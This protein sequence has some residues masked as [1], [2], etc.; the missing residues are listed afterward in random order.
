MGVPKSSSTNRGVARACAGLGRRERRGPKA[1]LVA[2]AVRR[3]GVAEDGAKRPGGGIARRGALA[4]VPALSEGGRDGGH[5]H[6]RAAVG[7]RGAGGGLGGGAAGGGRRAD[8]HR[9][10]PAPVRGLREPRQRDRAGARA[11]LRDLR[12]HFRRPR[13]GADRGGFR[14]QARGRPVEGAEADPAGPGGHA[15]RPRGVQR[16]QRPARLRASRRGAAH[17]PQRRQRSAHRRKLQPLGAA[18]LVLQRPDRA[19]HGA[20]ALRP[21]LPPRLSRR[22][23]LRRRPADDGGVPRPLARR[24]RRRR[25]RILRPAARDARLRPLARAHPRGGARRRVR[26]LRRQPGDPV[27]YPVRR[28]RPQGRDRADR[29]RLSSSRRSTSTPRGRRRTGSSASSTTCRGST[30]TPTVPSRPPTAPATAASPPSTRSRATTPR[31]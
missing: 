31:T 20:V 14:G 30:T 26:L 22:R 9:R 25:R 16:R 4:M 18:H 27:R 24:R 5:D 15:R 6:G 17:R 21:R 7:G 12:Q 13:G 11:R 10:D 1:P 2:R 3:R 29:R 19:R 8:P 23:R 28:L